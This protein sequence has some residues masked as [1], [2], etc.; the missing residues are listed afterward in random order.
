MTI[1]LPRALQY[2]HSVVLDSYATLWWVIR[3]HFDTL[4]HTIP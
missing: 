3:A 1:L 2:R 4:L